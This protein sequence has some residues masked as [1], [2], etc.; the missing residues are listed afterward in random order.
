MDIDDPEGAVA[1]LN[2]VIAQGSE[3]QQQ[4]ARKMLQEVT[5]A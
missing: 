3:S 2:E 4:Q 1:L 5:S